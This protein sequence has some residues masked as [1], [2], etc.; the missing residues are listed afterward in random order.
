MCVNIKYTGEL[1]TPDKVYILS[2]A[3]KENKIGQTWNK[4]KLIFQ[5]LHTSHRLSQR[6]CRFLKD[7]SALINQSCKTLA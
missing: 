3:D 4:E 6:K 7:I 5:K 2:L 1:I